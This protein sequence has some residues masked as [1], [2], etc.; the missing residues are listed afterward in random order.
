MDDKQ[1]YDVLRQSMVPVQDAAGVTWW[2]KAE[3]AATFDPQLT[4]V[5]PPRTKKDYEIPKYG[6]A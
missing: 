2:T 3:S 4:A 1:W 5:L 6:K